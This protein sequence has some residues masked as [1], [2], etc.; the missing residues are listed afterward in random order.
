MPLQPLLLRMQVFLCAP[1]KFTFIKFSPL[2]DIGPL[3][4]V[5]SKGWDSSQDS[6]LQAQ[7]LNLHWRSP[8]HYCGI[9]SQRIKSYT[10][11]WFVSNFPYLENYL[12][13]SSLCLIFLSV[14]IYKLFA[15]YKGGFQGNQ[16]L[17]NIYI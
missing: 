3:N 15:S 17:N 10:K 16:A 11:C 9:K 4:W 14:P 6:V 2:E 8:K 12:A 7:E 5:G 13:W 1:L